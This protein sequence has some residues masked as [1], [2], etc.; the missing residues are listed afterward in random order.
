MAKAGAR[1]SKILTH[2]LTISPDGDS[3]GRL[4]SDGMGE[5]LGSEGGGLGSRINFEAVARAEPQRQVEACGGESGSHGRPR[6]VLERA[7]W[8]GRNIKHCLGRNV[9]RSGTFF[10]R[11]IFLQLSRQACLLRRGFRAR[12]GGRFRC[13]RHFADALT[14]ACQ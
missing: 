11:V 12:G 4:S 1:V 9:R 8:F 10:A 14:G 3:V 5:G 6:P 7:S 2:K 13:R